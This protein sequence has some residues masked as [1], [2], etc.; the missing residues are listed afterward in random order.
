[1]QA[2][3]FTQGNDT[4]LFTLTAYL[5]WLLGYPTQA[6]QR[7]QEMLT[8]VQELAPPVGQANA[9]YHAARLYQ[10]RQDAPTV[11]AYVDRAISLDRLWPGALSGPNI[12]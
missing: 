5:L 9:L 1:M 12:E 4:G 7:S 8:L 11:Q 2:V 3:A 6:R 10:L